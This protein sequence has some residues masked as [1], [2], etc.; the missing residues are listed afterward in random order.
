MNGTGKTP[1]V[2]LAL[3][4]GLMTVGLG[5]SARWPVWLWAVP[6]AVAVVLAILLAS[7]RSPEPEPEPTYSDEPSWEETRVVDVALPSRVPDYDFRFSATVWWRPIPNATGLVHADPAGLAVET[8]LNRA[9]EVTEH[10]APER[11]DLLLHRLNGLLGTQSRDASRLVEAMGGRVEIRLSEDDRNRLGKLSEVRKTEEVWEHERRYEQSKRAY[12]G[13]DVLKSTGSALVWWLSRHDDM[14]TEAV[15]L[16]GPLARLSAAANDEAVADLYQ[17]LVPQPVPQAV[18]DPDGV[19]PSDRPGDG[20][21]GGA[22]A[23][24]SGHPWPAGPTGPTRGP[25]VI[26]PLNQFLDDVEVA[27]ESPERKV[28]AHR[29]AEFTDAVGRPEH[30]RLIRES[31]RGDEGGG[32]RAAG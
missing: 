28:C 6:V 22:E 23:G 17:H 19:A 32:P 18:P 5:L 25:L 7:A 31:L 1:L 9:R 12:L 11:L 2:S 29:M 13:D 30:A 21:E 8:V 27:R 15:D 24:P 26:G 20:G 4:A 10:E 14:V 3:A 16:I